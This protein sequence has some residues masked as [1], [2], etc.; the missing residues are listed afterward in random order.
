MAELFGHI[1]S[2]T[3]IDLVDILVVA[4]VFYYIFNLL[5]NTRSSVALRGMITLLVFSFLVYFIARVAR[6]TAVGLIFEKVWIIIV[7]V[8]MIVFQ[9]EFKRVLTEVGQLRIFRAFFTQSGEFIVEVVRAVRTLSSRNVGALI[10]I[11]R[12]N[13]LK[14]YA[15]T[16]IEIDA[17]VQA[18][19][20]RTI[21]SQYSPTHD[22]ALIISGNRIASV[23]CILPLTSD[24]M[25]DKELGTRHRAALGISEETD[26]LVVVASEETGAISLARDGK[27]ERNLPAEALKKILE[28]C[29]YVGESGK[30]E[31]S[32][33][34]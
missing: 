14:A 12:R 26:A 13:S 7:L 24:P 27:L 29:L 28:Q 6:L 23:S 1:S 8:F 9:H 4:G 25:V 19:L 3:W 33:V 15:E 2:M 16:G 11:E 17:V 20:I 22:G 32:H 34:A 31:V 30:K 21:F 18:E 10:V 5:R